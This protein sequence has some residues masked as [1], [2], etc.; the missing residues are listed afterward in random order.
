MNE[1][2]LISSNILI[3]RNCIVIV[4]IND[5]RLRRSKIEINYKMIVF[6]WLNIAIWIAIIVGIIKGIK[7]IKKFINRT[8]EMDK[9]LDTI[10]NQLKKKDNE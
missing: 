3:K 5:K 10:L 8:K 2:Y 9:K 7:E 4:N 6:N 1:N